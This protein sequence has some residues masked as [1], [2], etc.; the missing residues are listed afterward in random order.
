M[1]ET[2]GYLIQWIDWELVISVGV[3]GLIT[4]GVSW[5][6]YRQAGKELKTEADRLHDLDAMILRWLEIGGD[7]RVVRD[8]QGR[9]VALKRDISVVDRIDIEPGVEKIELRRAKERKQNDDPH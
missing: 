9:P 6:F 4:W 1:V 2:I 7:L 8:E 3:G 5:W